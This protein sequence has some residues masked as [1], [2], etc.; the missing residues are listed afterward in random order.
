MRLN[1]NKCDF[2]VESR[3]FL[4]FQ[5]NKRGIEMTLEQSK[6]IFQM[7][8]LK[9]KEQMQTLKG[10]LV[11][12][13]KF[14]SRYSDRLQP[15][16]KA[17]KGASSEEWGPKCDRAFQDIKDY[18]TSP[19]ILSWLV[20]GEEVYLYLAAS[21]VGVSKAL[22]KANRD[23]R[24][25]PI[26]FVS[27]MLTDVETR[28]IEFEQ[29]TLALRMAAKKLHPYFQAHTIVVLISYPIIDILQKPNALER[30]LKWVIELSEFDIVYRPRSA[31]KGQVLA[32]F[33][34]ELSNMPMDIISEPL[35]I[36]ETEGSSKAFRKG[37]SMVL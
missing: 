6:A 7:H 13:N 10:K 31:I 28:Y 23:G 21:A 36:F 26:Y 24:Q 11:A 27:K 9:T 29:I 20:E 30:L 5:V 2:R 32:D 22:V 3:K 18:L 37:I 4:G 8:P 25:R 14:I 12:F 35:W 34:V 16:F 33:I 15:F 1:P 17:Q 19:L